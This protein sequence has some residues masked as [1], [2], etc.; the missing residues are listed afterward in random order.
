MQ[1]ICNET[2]MK[3]TYVTRCF[4]NYSLRN[5]YDEEKI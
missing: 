4:V 3:G 1:F 5:E 2:L